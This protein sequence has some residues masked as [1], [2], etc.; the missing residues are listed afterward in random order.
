MALMSYDPFRGKRFIISSYL[1]KARLVRL[2]HDELCRLK[3]P[4]RS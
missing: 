4:L 2:I 3:A 1:L